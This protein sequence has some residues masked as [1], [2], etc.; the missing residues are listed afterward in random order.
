[1]KRKPLKDLCAAGGTQAADAAAR[2]AL[3][4][5]TCGGWLTN[6]ATFGGFELVT[7]LIAARLWHEQGETVRSL[8]TVRR[9]VVGLGPRAV[10]VSQIRDEA[11]YAALIGDRDGATQAYRHYLALRANAELAVGPKVDEV[12][13]GLHA[14]QSDATDG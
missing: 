1:M 4:G 11:H 6:A 13:A 3:T 5:P 9:R 12:S 7:N 2:V 10:H 14:L 8:A